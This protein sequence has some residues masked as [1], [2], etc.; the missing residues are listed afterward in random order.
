MSDPVVT[1]IYASQ[2]GNCEEISMDLHTTAKEKG[3]TSERYEF[4][5]HLKNFDL[6]NPKPKRVVVILCSSTGDGE[7]PD[8]GNKFYRYLCKHSKIAKNEKTPESR[9][10]SHLHYTILGLGD[11]DY[12]SF[13]KTPKTVNSAF[14]ALGAKF[15]HYF[16]KADEAIGLENEVEPWIK[17]FWDEL[18]TT[19]VEA[20]TQAIDPTT[21]VVH[22]EESKE[23]PEEDTTKFEK[24]KICSKVIES[25]EYRKVL[26]L[27]LELD[28]TLSASEDIQPGS[29]ISVMPKNSL[30]SVKAFINACKWEETP[31]LI[32]KLTTEFDFLKSVNKKALG[33]IL[34]E[35]EHLQEK[36]V[37]NYLDYLAFVNPSSAVS[38]D[39]LET[40]PK[41]KSRFYSL[42]SD[43]VDTNKLEIGFTV[44]EHEQNDVFQKGNKIV[45]QGV[46]SNYLYRLSEEEK[47]EFDIK[48]GKSSLF[49]TTKKELDNQPPLIFISHGTAV[50][51]FIG[52]L[53]RLRRMLETKEIKGLRGIEFYFGIRN[54]THDYLFKDELSSLFE[55]FSSTNPDSKFNIHLAE[56]RPNEFEE[57]KY[58]Q[59]LINLN[60]SDL[61]Y[62]IQVNKAL[63][64]ICGNGN[65][66]V[67]AAEKILEEITGSSE[68]LQ[69]LHKDGRYKKEIWTAN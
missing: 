51:P 48:L 64:Y 20:K 5:Q 58:V 22:N 21:E 30:G 44:E 26:R 4:D 45:K 53:K 57:R 65:T 63:I 15:F 29:Y 7:C 33:S 12:S 18:A 38:M 62:K 66:M 3:Y 42:S 16:G 24:A 34:G 1:F 39:I 69:D 10:F 61:Q 17:G 46:C 27:E 56:S 40:V 67:K 36:A 25:E 68:Q 35:S 50:V 28:R 13:H 54:K 8:N 19:V 52:V 31:E 11:S 14:E 47:V 32:E 41:M 59:D 60:T 23:M 6:T 37:F 9:I 2:T 43:P 49:N 55:Y